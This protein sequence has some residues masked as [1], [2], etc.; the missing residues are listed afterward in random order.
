MPRRTLA[1][2][3]ETLTQLTPDDLAV[4]AGAGYDASGATCPLGDCFDKLSH[5]L[6]CV[7]TYNCPTYTC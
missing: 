6:G 5:K 4:V 2:R 7:G 3:R 1:L